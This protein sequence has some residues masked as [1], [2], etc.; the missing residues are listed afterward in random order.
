MASEL[1]F[2]RERMVH[3]SASD[4]A[5]RQEFAMLAAMAALRGRFLPRPPAPGVGGAPTR[6]PGY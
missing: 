2:L 3:G 4:D 5:R 1:A 6:P